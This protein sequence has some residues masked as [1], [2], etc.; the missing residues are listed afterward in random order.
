MSL[1]SWL[2]YA[3]NFCI[4]NGLQEKILLSFVFCLLF[5]NLPLFLHRISASFPDHS[6]WVYSSHTVKSTHQIPC[7][8]SVCWSPGT[9][10][11]IQL[12]QWAFSHLFVQQ[13][14]MEH[15]LF[16]TQY[17]E[18]LRNTKLPS[19]SSHSKRS[20][21][22]TGLP[23]RHRSC[24]GEQ[25]PCMWWWV[26]AFCFDKTSKE[27]SWLS[28]HNF[29]SCYNVPFLTTSKSTKPGYLITEGC[30]FSILHACV[31]WLSA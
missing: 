26:V 16:V 28:F 15:L 29:Q 30:G 5:F 24:A 12:F 1:A 22:D 9:N 6:Y 11:G 10:R 31:C 4:K 8:S 14:F 23:S 19:R 20:P 13:E 27:E 17:T 18:G 3:D 25:N 2:M 21:L 7:I